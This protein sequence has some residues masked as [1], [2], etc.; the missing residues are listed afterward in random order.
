MILAVFSRRTLVWA[1]GILLGIIVLTL[2]VWVAVAGPVTV[3]RVIRYGDTTIDDFTH[4]PSRRLVADDSLFR[5]DE[6][7]DRLRVPAVVELDGGTRTPLD[8]VLSANDTIAFLVV[9]DDTILFEEYY[10]GHTQSS[11]SQSFSVAKSIT[12]ALVGAAIKDEIITSVDQPVTDFVPELAAQGFDVVT[13]EHLLTMTS[14]TDYVENDNPFGI[15]VILN[16]TPALEREILGFRV[17]DEPGDQFRYKSGDN[18]LLAL[19][20]DRALGSQTITDYTQETLWTPLG[21][22]YDGV[23]SLDHEG[24]GLEKTWCCL[25]ATARDFAK[26]GR[27]YLR[28]GDWDGRRIVASEWVRQ[29]TQVGAVPEAEW[30]SGFEEIGLWN[31]GYQWWLVS[32]EDG[33]SLAL[34]K[35]GQF[36]YVNPARNVIIV[37]LGWSTGELPTGQ[38]ISLFTYLAHEV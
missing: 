23:W 2:V 1:L 11:L 38:W 10:Q 14:G 8:E 6:G 25:A 17:V 4:Y 22:E 29:S 36:L 15:H 35:D 37:R 7:A 33:D 9:K 30:P 19:S 27:L 28:N 18:A 12:A 24:D 5:F 34:G 16:Y 21:M 31:Y 20:L 26:L 3:F 32:R 13:L